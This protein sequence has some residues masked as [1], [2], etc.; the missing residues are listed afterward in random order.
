MSFESWG[1]F[2]PRSSFSII[3][4]SKFWQYFNKFP[5][6]AGD[7]FRLIGT[8]GCLSSI[9]DNSEYYN[10]DSKLLKCKDDYKLSDGQCIPKT[11]YVR[12]ETCSTKIFR[13]FYWFLFSW[14]HIRISHI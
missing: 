7:K 3:S 12:C 5:L 13:W 10:E 11:C 8:N 2:N 14:I 6:K 9:P 4:S 1:S